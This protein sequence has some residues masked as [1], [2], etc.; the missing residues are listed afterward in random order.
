[1]GLPLDSDS[2]RAGDHMTGS[3]AKRSGMRG[4]APGS[5]GVRAR[6]LLLEAGLLS[7]ISVAIRLVNIGRPPQTD[8]LF[9]VMAARSLLEDGD[10]SVEN[11]APYTRARLFTFLVAG[12]FRLS[13]ESLVAARLPALVAGVA[14]VLAVFL[15][16]RREVGRSAAWTAALLLSFYSMS[17]LQ[18]QMVRFYTAHAL[19]FWVGAIAVYY[20]VAVNGRSVNRA[21]LAAAALTCFVAAFHLQILTLVGLAGIGVWIAF[22]GGPGVAG[23]IRAAGHPVL[24]VAAL[25]LLGLLLSYGAWESGAIARAWNL[26]RYV[27]P[28]AADNRYSIRFYHWILYEQYAALWVLF[29]LTVLLAATQSPRI[30]GLCVSIFAVAFIFFS[31]A[32]WKD[33]HY[34]FLA[35]PGFFAISGIAIS[36]MVPRLEEWTANTLGGAR[37]PSMAAKRIPAT[38]RAWIAA[39]ILF[40]IATSG[41]TAQLY[42][43]IRG[44]GVPNWGM[45]AAAVRPIADSSDAVIT[46]ADLQALYFLRRNDFFL[47]AWRGE[48]AEFA[49]SRGTGTP[50]ISTPRSL[51]RVI[52]CNAS[53]LILIERRHWRTSWV[54]LPAT[55]DF[56]EANTTQLPVPDASHLMAFQWRRA[57]GREFVTCDSLAAP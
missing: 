38:A 57:P 25:S 14:L 37:P 32:A 12:I 29:P 40:A 39:A 41:A 42:K 13:G 49:P 22:I 36:T 4:R 52:E 17:I 45:A 33:E 23:R 44:S 24:I 28:W 10:L 15:W 27:D 56:I 1:M 54:V 53:G 2:P 48:Q 21:F 30:T 34:F 3:D 50:Q 47:M 8:E 5:I 18:S 11:A 20:S 9:H 55:A 51:Q 16:L 19:F 35:M 26:F 43:T 6:H 46:S 7:A 31:L